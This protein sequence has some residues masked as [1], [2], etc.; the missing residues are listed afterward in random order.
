[1]VSPGTAGLIRIHVLGH[2]KLVA[3]AIR[4]FPGVQVVRFG[5]RSSGL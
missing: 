2:F 5:F 4:T 3:L 1:M